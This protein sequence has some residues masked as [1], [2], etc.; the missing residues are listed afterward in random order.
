MHGTALV[1][2]RVS[3]L[4]KLG[5]KFLSNTADYLSARLGKISE[6]RQSHCGVAA[7][8]TVALAK[9]N[10]RSLTCG[11]YCGAKSAGTSAD[12]ADVAF[13]ISDLHN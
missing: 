4:F 11:G 10:V 9:N 7:E 5:H 8:M 1:T 3:G 6:Q 2:V 13:H 12:D